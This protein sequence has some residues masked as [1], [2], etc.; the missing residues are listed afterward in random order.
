[1]I[2]RLFNLLRLEYARYNA[3]QA[4][5]FDR[6]LELGYYFRIILRDFCVFYVL[7][8]FH[9]KYPKQRIYELRACDTQAAE[10]RSNRLLLISIMDRPRRIAYTDVLEKEP[11]RCRKNPPPPSAKAFSKTVKTPFPERTS[12]EY[13]LNSSVVWKG[14]SIHE[15]SDLLPPV[16]GGSR[17]AP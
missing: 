8:H 13:G 5:P 9:Y 11:R 1:M 14:R 10:G 4:E 17:Q 12:P 16:R 15:G 3:R 6:V 7:S 2:Q